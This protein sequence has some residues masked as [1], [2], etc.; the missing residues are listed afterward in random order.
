MGN[1]ILIPKEKLEKHLWEYGTTRK[2]K[3]FAEYG[4]KIIKFKLTLMKK[5][6]NKS[7]RF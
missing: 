6:K 4:S 7:A 2:G 5:I 1:S 3:S